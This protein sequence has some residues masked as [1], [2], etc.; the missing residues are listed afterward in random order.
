MTRGD[1]ATRD[2]LAYWAAGQQLVHH[3]NPYDGPAI[4]ALEQSVGF[5]HTRPFFMRNAP[6][7]F[8]LAWPLGFLG[9]RAGGILWSLALIAALMISVRMLWK[10]LGE[11]SDRLH[12]VGYVFPPVLACLL[13]GQMG[14]FLL[15]GITCFLLWRESKPF[16]AGAA[17]LVVAIK[18]HLFL[19]F[20]TVLLS[21]IVTQKR[22]RLLA[23]AV[24]A[25]TCSI[26]FASVID[27]A[28]WSQYSAMLRAEDLPNEWIPTVS[29]AFR[30]LVHRG[31][32]WLQLVPCVVASFL[33]FWSFWRN[34][35]QWDWQKEGLI[36]LALSVMAAPYAWVTDEAVVLPAIL[37]GLY[38][39]TSRQLILFAV[40]AV[41][42]LVEVLCGLAINSGFYIW[43]APAWFVWCAIV[44]SKQPSVLR[45][46]SDD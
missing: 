8:L 43:T 6:I 31:W 42:A 25:I 17:L 32:D 39:A 2:Y 21:W 4:L 19:A 16:L 35:R 27:P 34:R 44:N 20:G 29:L 24:A 41:I 18:P 1:L 46:T 7:A 11:P 23:G 36:V 15:L 33:G 38:R 3:H 37:F 9:F 30:L 14:L 10:M 13:G 12:L 45:Q 28:G 5:Q 40:L 22:F 26:L